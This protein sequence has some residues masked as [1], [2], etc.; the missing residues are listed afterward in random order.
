[1]YFDILYS[2]DIHTMVS[3]LDSKPKTEY[4]TDIKIYME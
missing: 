3:N 2:K 4:L 1:M